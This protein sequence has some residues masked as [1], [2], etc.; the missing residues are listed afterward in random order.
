MASN[1]PAPAATGGPSSSADAVVIRP[2]ADADAKAVAELYNRHADAPNPVDRELD[3]RM[4]RTELAERGTVL[5]L[6]AELDGEVLGTLGMFRSSGRRAVPGGE[7]FGDMFFLSPLIRS[8]A[9][10]GRMF[11]QAFRTLRLQGIGAIRLTVNPTNQQALPLYRQLGCTLVGPADA[12]EDGNIELVSY[13]PRIVTRLRR[14]H[15]ELIPPGLRMTAA[16]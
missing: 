8:G 5:F 7:V 2:Y 14:D 1:R 11:S 3:A 6:V 16:Q 9:A 4:V 12:A 13:M 10:A 15:E